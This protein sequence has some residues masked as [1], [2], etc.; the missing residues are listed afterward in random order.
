[1]GLYIILI[2]PPECT[3]F[4][5]F[6]LPLAGAAI[7]A[8]FFV[9]FT[10]SVVFVGALETVAVEAGALLVVEA[11]FGAIAIKGVDREIQG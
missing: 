4:L 9:H 2:C 1:M 5:F 7:L 11:G 10:P 6:F 3:F 8:V